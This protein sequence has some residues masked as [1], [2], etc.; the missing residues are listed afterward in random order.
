MKSLI[1]W[2]LMMLLMVSPVPAKAQDVAQPVPDTRIT[3]DPVQVTQTD[4]GSVYSWGLTSELSA[5]SLSAHLEPFCG[6]SYGALRLHEQWVFLSARDSRNCVLWVDT[7]NTS[8]LSAVL[9]MTEG[10][11]LRLVSPPAPVAG[12]VLWQYTQPGQSQSWL[13]QAEAGWQQVLQRNGWGAEAGERH[14]RRGPAELDVMELVHEQEA[15]LLLICRACEG[16]DL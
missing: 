12:P 16:E 10:G 13:L 3:W 2:V 1:A 6:A 7:L 14:W 4:F 11:P 5:Q 9:S 8:P 15:Y